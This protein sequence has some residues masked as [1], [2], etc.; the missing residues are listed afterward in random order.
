MSSMVPESLVRKEEVL[1]LDEGRVGVR[2]ELS[3]S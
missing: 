3:D 1:Y 2:D